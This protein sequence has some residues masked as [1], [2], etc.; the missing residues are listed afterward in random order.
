VSQVHKPAPRWVAP[1]ARLGAGTSG[2]TDKRRHSVTGARNM[3]DL[4]DVEARAGH[5]P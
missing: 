3:S 2:S 4:D 5:H 1:R